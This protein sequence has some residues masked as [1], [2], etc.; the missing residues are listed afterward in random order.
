MSMTEELIFHTLRLVQR[1]PVE[2][3]PRRIVV[4]LIEH[5]DGDRTLPGGNVVRAFTSEVVDTGA[6]V[7]ETIK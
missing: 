3:L 2:G 6:Y 7:P 4:E 1:E 5:R